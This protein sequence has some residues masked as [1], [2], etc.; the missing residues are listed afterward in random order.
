MS[1]SVL[2][3][4]EPKNELCRRCKRRHFHFH[5][6]FSMHLHMSRGKCHSLGPW[7]EETEGSLSLS[8][9]GYVNKWLDLVCGAALKKDNVINSSLFCLVGKFLEIL[10]R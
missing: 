1:Y 9:N 3:E 10:L 8:N 5:I 6:H 4:H 7:G 2:N